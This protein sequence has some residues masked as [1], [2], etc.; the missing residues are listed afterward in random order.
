MNRLSSRWILAYSFLLL[1][2]HEAHELAHVIT[3][4]V[5]CGEWATRDFNAWQLS[6]CATWLPTA[7][8]PIFSYLVMLL[9]AL[10]GLRS[11]DKRWLGVAIVF[12]A[13]PF[14]RIFTA[15]MGGGDE[16]LIAK[17]IAGVST[18]TPA[19]HAI[20][21]VMVTVICGA[22]IVAG[23]RAMKGLERRALW[24]VFVLL[25]PMVLTG[26]LL[27]WIGNRLLRSGVLA[28]PLVAGAPL[29]VMLVTIVAVACTALT[30][31]WLFLPW[32][33]PLHGER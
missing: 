20:V 28:T 23:W 29:L 8:G 3:G 11:K 6:D 5:F 9:G 30:I 2:V 17:R 1:A 24:F 15:V 12:A 27:F 33:P 21:L 16:M 32:A 14:A 13:N 31:R 19:L 26:T 25:W 18:R 10:I 4:R 7:A 22:A